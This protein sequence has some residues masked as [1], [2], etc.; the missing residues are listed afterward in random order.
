V[1]KDDTKARQWLTKAAEQGATKAAF[2]L[3]IR[4]YEAGEYEES[5][6]SFRKAAALGH[7]LAQVK[8]GD[9][10]SRGQGVPQDNCQACQWYKN[11]ADLGSPEG[12]VELGLCYYSGNGCKAPNGALMFAR[13]RC[14]AVDLFRSAAERGNVQGLF[15]IGLALVYGD[16]EGRKDAEAGKRY[17]ERAALGGSSEAKQELQKITAGGPR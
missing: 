16:C 3:G 7:P 8:M 10:F 15:N 12:Q 17:L 14:K 1:A 4:A 6:A 5:A 11:S 9:I 2:E 13:D